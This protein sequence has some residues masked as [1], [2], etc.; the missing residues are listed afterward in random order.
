MYHE[1]ALRKSSIT[2]GLSITL[3]VCESNVKYRHNSCGPTVDLPS[4]EHMKHT[5]VHLS[6]NLNEKVKVFS[7]SLSF[8]SESER[9]LTFK[10]KS[11]REGIPTVNSQVNKTSN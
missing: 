8:G 1:K 10:S 7:L 6:Y 11:V 2:V 3:T 4:W 5:H 9:L